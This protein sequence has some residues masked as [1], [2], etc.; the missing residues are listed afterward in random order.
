ME[1]EDGMKAIVAEAIFQ[2]LDQGKRD[3][4]LRDAIS[5]LLQKGSTGYNQSSKL[6]EA[7]QNAVSQ[8]AKEIVSD[9]LK[10]DE[11]FKENLKD[12][13]CKAFDNAFNTKKD[14][15]VD[16]ITDAIM[17]IWKMNPHFV[18][19]II[20]FNK[21]YRLPVETTPT[22]KNERLLAFKSVLAEELD[23]VDEIIDAKEEE[24]LVMIADWLGDMIVYITSEAVKYGIDIEKALDIIMQS[25]FSKLDAN[26][27][28]IYDE[29]GKVLKGPN[30]WKPEPKLK[31]MINGKS[32]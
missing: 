20:K 18:S 17:G 26:G 7:F 23:E 32:T 25:N 4:L 5:H 31:D 6:E 22:L 13:I 24:K 16:Q 9:K 21:M 14:K 2:K 19:D 15:L 30:Y 3:T 29:R 10:N 8:C 27:N 1:I 11:K 28:P 12:I